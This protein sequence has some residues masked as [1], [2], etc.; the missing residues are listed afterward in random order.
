MKD[1]RRHIGFGENDQRAVL[2]RLGLIL[3]LL[4]GRERAALFRFGLIALG[5]GFGLIRLQVGANVVADVH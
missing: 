2:L 4:R 3:G 5:V 1:E